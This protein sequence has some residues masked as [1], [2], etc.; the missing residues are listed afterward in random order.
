M[1]AAGEETAALWSGV[2]TKLGVS[3]YNNHTVTAV[4][5]PG[6]KGK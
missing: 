1:R 6:G 4:K 3:E 5:N 2:L